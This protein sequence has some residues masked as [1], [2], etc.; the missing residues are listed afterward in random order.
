[1]FFLV[2]LVFKTDYLLVL[3]IDQ[4]LTVQDL[5]T[6]TQVFGESSLFFPMFLHPTINI[7][8]ITVKER[9]NE[10]VV[11]IVKRLREPS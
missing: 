1:M 6:L 2:S 10:V 9:R 7:C 11:D 4:I 8:Q 3:D 5:D